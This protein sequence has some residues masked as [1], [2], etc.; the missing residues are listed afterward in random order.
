MVA[1]ARLTCSPTHGRAGCCIVLLGREARAT[2]IVAT[3]ELMQG[4]D[5]R[6]IRRLTVMRRHAASLGLSDGAPESRAAGGPGKAATSPPC[7]PLSQ[8][9][10]RNVT[11]GWD[12]EVKNGSCDASDSLPLAERS[13]DMLQHPR[14]FS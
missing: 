3:N 5:H 1:R 4:P 6:V 10:R 8:S 14:D 12:A 13:R 9:T 11:D 7:P 2:S